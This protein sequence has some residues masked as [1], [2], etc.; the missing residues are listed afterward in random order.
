AFAVR[1]E[2][3][4]DTVVLERG[5]VEVSRLADRSDHVQLGP[6]DTVTAN[7]KTLSS[8]ARGDPSELLA[9]REGR[10]VFENQPLSRVLA[11]L[12]RYYGVT[13]V[14][15]DSRV[16]NLVVT[17]NYRLDDVPG[18]IRTLADAA[19]VSMTRLPGGL[20]ILR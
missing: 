20:I 9:W 12:R 15:I 17:G 14:V 13:V 10:I 7:D 3:N 8:V 19:G 2:S 16:G 1:A 11:E 5:R 4:A 6:G 18:A